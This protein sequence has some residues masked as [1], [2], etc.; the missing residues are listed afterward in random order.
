MQ[1]Y[2]GQEV[3]LDVEYTVYGR[4]TYDADNG[5]ITSWQSPTLEITF[6]KEAYVTKAQV[7]RGTLSNRNRT[8][9]HNMYIS[10]VYMYQPNPNIDIY[11]HITMPNINRNYSFSPMER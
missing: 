9:N 3:T 2:K 11:E 4:L 7:T 1:S 8:I 6:E 10:T 5:E